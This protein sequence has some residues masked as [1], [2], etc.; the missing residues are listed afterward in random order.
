MPAAGRPLA[1]E[2]AAALAGW[3]WDVA[4]LQ[5]VPPWWPRRLGAACGASGRMVLTSRNTGLPLR[6]VLSARNPDLLTAYGGGCNAML[7]RGHAIVAHRTLELTR[8][9]ERRAMHGIELDG[10]LGWVVN[11]HGSTYPFEQGQADQRLSHET[12]LAW[13]G[14]APL[15]FGGD[16]NQT[17]PRHPGMT[18]VAGHHVDHVFVRGW[19]PDGKGE[20][21][22]TAP[23]SDH[24][25]L[26]VR[27]RGPAGPRPP[28][29][30]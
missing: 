4:L 20:T 13:A 24:P 21:I 25:A 17:R 28:A 6:R 19:E 11:L 26:R 14:D 10:G 27:L 12:A 22:V 7:V 1:A 18:H 29:S 9:P 2:F 30:G 16:L 15:I 23:L 5:E 3:A 8:K